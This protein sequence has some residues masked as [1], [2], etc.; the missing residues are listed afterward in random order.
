MTA[1]LSITKFQTQK[2]LLT[3]GASGIGKGYALELA[4]EG[5]SIYIVDK[6]KDECIFKWIAHS[7]VAS[8]NGMVLY[9]H[10]IFYLSPQLPLLNLI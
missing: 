9:L 2:L 6:N 8:P 4:R 7:R 1:L 5:F 10:R 3:G